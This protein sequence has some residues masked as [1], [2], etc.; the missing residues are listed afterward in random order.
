MKRIPITADLTAQIKNAVGEDVDPAGFAVFESISLNTLPLPGK[1]GTIFE[2]AVISLLTLRQMADSV[3]SGNHLPIMFNHNMEGIPMGRA[4]AAGTNFTTD[5]SVELRTLFYIDETNAEMAAKVDAGSV[6]EVSVQFLASQ[7][8]CS[9]CDFDYR[10][11]TADWSHFADR[12]CEN[13]HTIGLDG[14]HVRLVGL[15]TFT[16]LSLVPRGAASNPKIVGR[17]ASKLTAPLQALAARGFEID[18]LFLTASKGEMKVDL[19]LILSQLTEQTTAAATATAALNAAVAE[20]DTAQA[21]LVASEARVAELEA[22]ENVNPDAEAAVAELAEAKAF[23]SES[24]I[25]MA[26]AAG[27]VDPVAPL[28]FADLKAGIELHQSSLAA[29][30]PVGGAA[31]STQAAE[32]KD[33]SKFNASTA[34]AFVVSR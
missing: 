13:G 23:L 14:V 20:R 6:D 21:A 27:E 16:E 19:T 32:A 17:S 15:Q 4:F 5:G 25:K 24:F 29:L 1:T 30:I 22:A 18:E 31:A 9:E 11:D 34:A 3:N 33:G 28:I 2:N 8:L 12:T 10:G 26:T 7:I